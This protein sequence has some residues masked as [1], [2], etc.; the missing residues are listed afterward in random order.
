[1]QKSTISRQE[2]RKETRDAVKQNRKEAKQKY[3]NNNSDLNIKKLK[4]SCRIYKK[5]YRI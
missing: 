5:M 1:M 4:A 2:I 3:T